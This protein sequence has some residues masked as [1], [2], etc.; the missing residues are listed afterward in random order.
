MKTVALTEKTFELLKSLKEGKET[1]DE[2]I[3]DLVISK[4]EIPASMFGALKGK[5][6]P[7]TRKER[8]DMSRDKERWF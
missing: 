4:K 1:F 2:V 5:S 7:F 3:Y 6:K 8:L